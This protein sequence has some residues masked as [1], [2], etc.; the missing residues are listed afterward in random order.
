MVGQVGFVA[1]LIAGVVSFLSPCVL[2]LIPGYLSFITGMSTTELAE[3]DRPLG[4][5]LIP[6]LL[7]VLGFTIVFVAFG[8]SASVLGT[9]LSAYRSVVEKVAG[10]LVIAFG[11]LMLGI[12]KV[13]WLYGEA[14]FDLEKSR[15]FGRGASL[16]M[17]M[18]FAAGWS[19]CVGPVLGSILALAG[20]SGSV[21]RGA[22]LLLVYSAGLGVPFIAVALVFGRIRGLLRWLTRH[23]LVINRISGSIMIAVG[24]LIF[25]GRLEALATWMQ[26]L[27]PP[28]A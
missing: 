18:A 23:S 20:S 4:T 27:L 14:R 28:I 9:F 17:G 6:A 15:S 19:P 21:G 11:V 1:A 2:P 13:P 7:F 16:V 26:R 3:K 25:F 24:V 10:L 5:V 12:I 22:L 8:A